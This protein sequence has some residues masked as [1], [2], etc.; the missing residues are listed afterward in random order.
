MSQCQ[1]Y[2]RRRSRCAYRCRLVEFWAGELRPY[3]KPN[4]K[5]PGS[6]SAITFR[7][8]MFAAASATDRHRST[9]KRVCR[10]PFKR[11][12]R[13]WAGHEMSIV[14]GGQFESNQIDLFYNKNEQRNKETPQERRRVN[15]ALKRKL[16][17]LE[18]GSKLWFE[19]Y[20]QNAAP[21]LLAQHSSVG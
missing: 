20:R 3:L 13:T 17:V 8:R 11:N 2:L 1:F 14:S 15:K 21:Y 12:K 18:N 9:F 10:A 7:S 5:L 6:R 4:R 19:D 16:L